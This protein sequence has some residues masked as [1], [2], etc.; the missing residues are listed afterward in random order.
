MN[1]SIGKTRSNQ[2]ILE[3]SLDKKYFESEWTGK[4]GK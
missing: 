2:R 4:S 1:A 3:L